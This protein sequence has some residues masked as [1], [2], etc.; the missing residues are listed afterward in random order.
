MKSW[1]TCLRII[2]LG[3]AEAV[4]FTQ[5]FPFPHQLRVVHPSGPASS[6]GR[7]IREAGRVAGARG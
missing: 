7:E 6:Q 2:P 3:A 5:H 4:P 1:K